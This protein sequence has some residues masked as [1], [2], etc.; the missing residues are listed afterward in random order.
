MKRKIAL[1]MTLCMLTASLA[2]CSDSS[3]GRSGRSNSGD[4]SKSEFDDNDDNTR[5]TDPTEA[6]TKK[7]PTPSP[8][9]APSEPVV[10]VMLNENATLQWVDY[11]SPDGYFT[12]RVPEG[13]YVAYNNI[14]TIGYEIQVTDPEAEKYFYFSTSLTGFPS[15]EN[16]DYW[17]SVAGSYGL[18]LGDKGYISPEP[19]S[20]SLFSNSGDY[21]GYTDFAVIDYLGENGYGGEIIKANVNYNGTL[22]EGLFSS[23]LIDLDLYYSEMSW[24]LVSGTAIMM[25]PVE[26]FTDWIGIMVDIFGSVVFTEDYYAARQ[27]AWDQ[28]ISTSEMIAYNADVMSDMIM[29]SWEQSNRSSDITSQEYS[30][31]TLGRDRV[32]DT[33][34]GD[35]YYTDIGWSDNYSGSR[36][37]PVESGSD[38]YLL[39]VTG[40]IEG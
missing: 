20:E 29:D 37:E 34:T 28:T 2:A 21:F 27:A 36:Y 15:Q 33:E 22:Y 24:D 13:W 19:T 9:P 39:P 23:S 30:D 12:I 14:D 31:A 25:T 3:S 16:F 6:T 8:T 10:E 4:A 40:T 38:Y 32:Y 26:D 1:L 35:V 17:S 5:K 11:S 18:S 7:D